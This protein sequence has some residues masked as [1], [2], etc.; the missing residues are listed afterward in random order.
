MDPSAD[1]CLNNPCQNTGTCVVTA[2]RQF[3]CDCPVG[4]SGDLCEINPDD[5]GNHG[6]VNGVCVDDL[7]TYKCQCS[8]GFM[9]EMCDQGL[10]PPEPVFAELSFDISMEDVAAMGN[11]FDN[12]FRRDIARALQ[13]PTPAITVVSKTAGSVI[14][15]FG[16]SGDSNCECRN[17]R[18][19][20]L[21]VAATLTRPFLRTVNVTGNGGFSYDPSAKL[22]ELERLVRDPASRLFTSPGNR[23]IT[24]DRL[25]PAHN[26]QLAALDA[27][28]INLCDFYRQSLPVCF[29]ATSAA[30]LC[31]DMNCKTALANA[32]SDKA[33]EAC[34]RANQNFIGR[35]LPDWDQIC[36]MRPVIGDKL[37]CSDDSSAESL[38]A[39]YFTQGFALTSA[40][41]T[42]ADS[43]VTLNGDAYVVPDF[44]VHLDGKGDDI[45]LNLGTSY[46][47]DGEFSVSLWFTKAVCHIAGQWEV[48]Y[49]HN[50]NMEK[51]FQFFGDRGISG[52]VM[53]IGCS[54]DGDNSISTASGDLVRVII[55][56]DARTKAT[57]DWQ[58]GCAGS[59]DYLTDTWIHLVLGVSP[60]SLR[61]YADGVEQTTFGFAMDMRRGQ[62]DATFANPAYPDPNRLSRPLTGITTQGLAMVGNFLPNEPGW[63]AWLDASG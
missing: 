54:Q 46:S 23:L 1:P 14:V 37:D 27:D 47:T 56:D 13:I 55:Q 52:L 5:C 53:G 29:M 8:A 25:K 44:G 39:N 59:G 20:P 62:N 41:D 45:Q 16:I 36:G 38:I 43:K 24:L 12:M 32:K 4:T 10:A 22:A 49:M 50:S 7:G 31:G 28:G 35:G 19:G 15:V 18:L 57:F 6:C 17:G 34:A 30:T 3:A 42:A 63:S 51:G 60:W 26:R 33:V 61:L 11:M 58:V 40:A 9:G 48:L 2:N 21:T